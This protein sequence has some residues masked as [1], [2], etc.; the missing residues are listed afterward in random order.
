VRHSLIAILVACAALAA[1]CNLGPKT[2]P[3]SNDKR[4]EAL[5][6]LR[7]DKGL[8]ARLDGREGI[9]IGDEPDGPQVRF[10]LTGGEADAAQFEGRQEG[11]EQIGS[12]LLYTRKASDKALEDIETC[13]TNL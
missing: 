4:A 7:N 2:G 5:D 11:T 8:E 1:G 3:E 12:A 9:Q 10:F 13:L 6:C